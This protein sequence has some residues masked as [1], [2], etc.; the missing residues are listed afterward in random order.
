MKRMKFYL[1]KCKFCVISIHL[2]LFIAIIPNTLYAQL[3]GLR[4]YA[5]NWAATVDTT[6]LI[7]IVPENIYADENIRI[8]YRIYGMNELGKVQ[9]PTNIDNL[10]L[11]AGPSIRTIRT[12]D[13]INLVDHVYIFAHN[14]PGVYNIGPAKWLN[15]K[16]KSIKSEPL[17]IKV[18]SEYA[19]IQIKKDTAYIRIMKSILLG[20]MASPENWQN[21]IFIR[22]QMPQRVTGGSIFQVTYKLYLKNKNIAV[23]E[24]IPPIYP[25]RQIKN[26]TALSDLRK[27]S[28]EN[29]EGEWYYT[30]ILWQ[31]DLLAP[32]SGSMEIKEMSVVCSHTQT[33]WMEEE[34]KIP[35]Y[36]LQIE[37]D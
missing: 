33:P 35:P 26:I 10:K 3:G 36:T 12:G 2:S 25:T 27:T 1:N 5:K 32:S 14:G 29:W 19:P 23:Y 17:S 30:I 21:D 37:P 4:Q 7:A 16:G 24:I 20:K 8:K 11:V 9:L 18:L 15:S 22:R 28:L 34:A 13:V 6:R 31:A